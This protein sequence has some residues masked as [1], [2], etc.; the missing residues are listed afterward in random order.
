M[1]RTAL[2]LIDVQKGFDDKFWGARNNPDAEANIKALLDEW[3]RRRLPVV[4][5]RHD[6]RSSAS[7]LRPGQP[8]NDFKPELDGA[9]A[10][11]VFAKM[12]NSAF[13]GDVDLD[14]WLRTHGITSF[15]L[16]GIATN[17]CC[18]TTARVGGNLGYDV[19][20][21]LDATCAFEVEG[22]DGIVLTP[23]ELTRATATNLHGGGFAKISGTKEILA[24]TELTA[25]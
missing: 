9:R 17:F 10:D 1:T 14:G 24:N 21:A 8:G 15:V 13:H 19:T 3:Q 23:D 22:P 2:I 6:S 7:P 18:E 25:T 4:L 12:V 11:L 5:V 16:A 20:F